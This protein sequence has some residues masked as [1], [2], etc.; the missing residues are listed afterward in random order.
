MSTLFVPRPD[1]HGRPRASSHGGLGGLVRP[2]DIVV[3]RYYDDS[4]SMSWPSRGRIRPP[5][6][7]IT[8]END[9]LLVPPA[10][11]SAKSYPS[12]NSWTTKVPSSADGGK[13]SR[14]FQKSTPVSRFNPGGLLKSP[15][16]RPVTPITVLP[17]VA[18]PPVELA[19]SLLLPSQGFAPPPATP[20]RPIKLQRRG[21]DESD[22]SSLPS[23]AHSIST[24]SSSDS[25]DLFKGLSHAHWRA[26][27]L[28]SANGHKSSGVSKPFSAMTIEELL[29]SLHG[30]DS[31]TVAR[32]WLPEM[33]KR[34]SQLK[35]TMQ[36][37]EDNKQSDSTLMDVGNVSN[38]H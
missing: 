22:S 30:C 7:Q 11:W 9:N 10:P 29:S 2:E 36:K 8:H 28:T 12:N 21:T 27:G 38:F 34:C 26:N 3:K 16:S 19:G 35:D 14:G 33:Q 13:P 5:P 25:M 1:I 23:L 18:P 32:V 20:P 24:E 17:S 31:S 4:E 15:A 37:S 6:L